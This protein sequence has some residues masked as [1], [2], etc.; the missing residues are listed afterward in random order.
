MTG[1]HRLLVT[2]EAVEFEKDRLK[3]KTFGKSP[4]I[5]EESI[6]RTQINKEKKTESSQHVTSWSWK[7]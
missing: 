1:E 5:V 7:H 6:E 3:P 4:I 2:D